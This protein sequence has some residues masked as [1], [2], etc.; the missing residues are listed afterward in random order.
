MKR[1]EL[2]YNKVED[3]I[4]NREI[5]AGTKTSMIKA[6]IE[7]SLAL[8]QGKEVKLVITETLTNLHTTNIMGRGNMSYDQMINF[9]QRDMAKRMIT[10]M[11]DKDFN[12]MFLTNVEV[13]AENRQ[14]NFGLK[15][16]I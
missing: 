12:Q 11:S 5:G 2:D 3:I 8:M 7:N 10:E 9:V 15:I 14:T 1:V 13:D 16:T 4:G 6:L